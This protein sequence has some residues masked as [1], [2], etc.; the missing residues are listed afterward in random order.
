M[1][2]QNIQEYLEWKAYATSVNDLTWAYYTGTGSEDDIRFGD[3]IDGWWLMGINE[4][5]TD[6]FWFVSN[7]DY[8]EVTRWCVSWNDCNY[9]KPVVKVKKTNIENVLFRRDA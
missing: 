3:F 2:L 4:A 1:R 7:Q 8:G 5:K 6:R 9:L